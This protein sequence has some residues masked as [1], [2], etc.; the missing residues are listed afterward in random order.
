[1][2][3]TCSRHTNV[4]HLLNSLT[5]KKFEKYYQAISQLVPHINIR[6]FSLLLSADELRPLLFSH[7]TRGFMDEGLQNTG[8]RREN[9]H[10][11]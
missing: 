10:K 1:M 6:T 2:S 9:A 11:F 4:V 8:D 7:S 5:H 3:D